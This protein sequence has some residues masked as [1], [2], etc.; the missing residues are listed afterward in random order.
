MDCGSTENGERQPYS[1]LLG[2]VD[3]DSAEEPPVFRSRFDN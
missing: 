1:N 2:S 3:S